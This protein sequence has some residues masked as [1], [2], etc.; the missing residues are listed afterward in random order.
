VTNLHPHLTDFVREIVIRRMRILA[1]SV[2]SL[3][4]VSWSADWL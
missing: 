3:V 2:T 4:A 1:S